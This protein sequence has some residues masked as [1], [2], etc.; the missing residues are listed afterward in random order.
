MSAQNNTAS[1]LVL[2]YHFLVLG[3]AVRYAQI[4]SIVE[5]IVQDVFVEFLSRADRY[6]LK[7]D[8]RPL[9]H[10]IT[11]GVAA[12][13]RNAYW[14]D[15]SLQLRELDHYLLE[16]AETRSYSSAWNEED[17]QSL[18]FCLDKLTPKCRT[19]IELRYRNGLSFRE[20]SR[21]NFGKE[22]TLFKTVARIRDSLQRCIMQ[23]RRR[24][25]E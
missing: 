17:I 20:L 12:K 9:L 10:Q 7:S 3:L 8:I 15:K 13:H 21:A 6:D 5:D 25:K 23:I 11:K 4:P 19:L 14:K 22:S 2:Q 1:Q 16:L 24:A 18:Q